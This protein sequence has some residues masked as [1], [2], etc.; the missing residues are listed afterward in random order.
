MH[1]VVV[2][3]FGRALPL[4]LCS[5]LLCLQLREKSKKI[6]IINWSIQQQQQRIKFGVWDIVSFRFVFAFIL[7]TILAFNVTTRRTHDIH[8]VAKIATIRSLLSL[9]Y[10]AAFSHGLVLLMCIQF[11]TM[12]LSQIWKLSLSLSMSDCEP[13]NW[14]PS[15]SHRKNCTR[16]NFN[17]IFPG[18]KDRQR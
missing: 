5:R 2:S 7:R 14:F 12:M 3:S 10:L 16:F 4:S 1:S 17:R 6:I 18:G 13:L 9:V 11:S 15:F 8:N